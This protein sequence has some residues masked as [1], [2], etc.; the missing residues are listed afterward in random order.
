MAFA[1]DIDLRSGG[2]FGKST[3]TAGT[4]ID[5]FIPPKAGLY[6]RVLQCVYTAAGTAHTITF[7]RPIGETTTS[8]AAAAS[9]AVIVLTAQPA[10]SRGGATNNVA[11]NDFLAWENTDGTFGYG[12]VSSVSSLTITLTAN[13]SKAISSGAKVWFLGIT[14]DTNTDGYPHPT[15]PAAASTTTSLSNDVIGVVS[16]IR[17]YDPILVQSNNA[18][19]AGAFE[20]VGVAYTGA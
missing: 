16:S 20:R 4:V 14:S 10:T 19:A 13:L 11:A 5:V 6:T 8:A 1:N 9:Q 2:H 3:Q 18:T 17:P 7:L 12:K 15:A